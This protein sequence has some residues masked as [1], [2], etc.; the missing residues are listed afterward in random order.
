MKALVIADYLPNLSE[1]LKAITI[2]DIPIPEFGE[3][4]VRIKIDGAPCNPSDIAFMRGM[5]AIK[6]TLPK[7]C[8]FEGTGI[9]VEAGKS[10]EAQHL[11]G[12]RVSTFSQ[13][14]EHG[15]W[16]EYFV[17]KASNCLVIH[18]EMPKEQAACFFVNPF[19]AYGLFDFAKKRKDQAIVQNAASGQVGTFVRRLAQKEGIPLINIVRRPKH[20]DLLKSEGEKY[21]LNLRDKNFINDFTALSHKLHATIAFDAIGGDHSGNLLNNMPQGS[22]LLLYGGL[23]GQNAANF[24]IL[25]SIFHKKS[26]SGFNLSDWINNTQSSD[27]EDVSSFLQELIVNKK[28]QTKIQAEVPMGNAYDVLYQYITKMSD[29]KIIFNPQL[30]P[31]K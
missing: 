8:G 31:N 27:Y 19:T 24:D 11:L 14:D 21:V 30:K 7:A 13:D 25:E 4:E 28:V 2:K 3:D 12:K 18:Q 9:V 20:I 17:A 26:F 1:M 22:H 6:K 15:T 23:S 5:Y 10:A 29:G 16:A